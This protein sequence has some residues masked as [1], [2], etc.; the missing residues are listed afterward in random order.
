MNKGWSRG[1]EIEGKL[2]S[3]KVHDEKGA[4]SLIIRFPSS[5]LNRKFHLLYIYRRL[6]I[7]SSSNQLN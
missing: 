6:R 1:R 7:R 4:E 3:G 2:Y 5:R